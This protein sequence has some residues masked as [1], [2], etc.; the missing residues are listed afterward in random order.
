MADTD[1]GPLPAPEDVLDAVRGHRLAEI[2][3]GRGL[4][5]HHLAEKMGVSQSHVYEIE[6]GSI[7]ERE[8]LSRY[9]LAL[10]GRLRQTIHFDDGDIAVVE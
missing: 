8:A 6:R 7:A 9:A 3:R 4:T 1:T 5:Q 2:R 10:G